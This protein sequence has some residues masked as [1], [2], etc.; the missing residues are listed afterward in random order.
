MQTTKVMG[1]SFKKKKVLRLYSIGF[2]STTV[3]NSVVDRKLPTVLTSSIFG[4]SAEKKYEALKQPSPQEN[5]GFDAQ[6]S[7]KM[8]ESF[9]AELG[10]LITHH[11]SSKFFQMLLLHNVDRLL[12]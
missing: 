11:I 3:T 8:L 4:V 7:D 9:L 5:T 6:L 2:L 1:T 10:V 12:Q